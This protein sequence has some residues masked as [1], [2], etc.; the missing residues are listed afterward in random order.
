MRALELSEK[1]YRMHLD[2]CLPHTEACPR[3]IFLDDDYKSFV[4]SLE[5][6]PP[7]GPPTAPKSKAYSALRSLPIPYLKYLFQSIRK[8]R[9]CSRR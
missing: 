7:E 4:E 9:H 3:A 2:F 6:A 1:V 8:R 5:A